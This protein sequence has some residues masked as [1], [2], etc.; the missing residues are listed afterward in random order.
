M[1]DTEITKLKSLQWPIAPFRKGRWTEYTSL[2]G[3]PINATGRI[4]FDAD[5]TEW[6]LTAMGLAHFDG[7]QFTNLTPEDGLPA[8]ASPLAIYLDHG[9]TLWMG[10]HDGL[11]RYNPGEGGK[12][13]KFNETGVPTDGVMEITGTPDGAVWWRT[14]KPQI[15][16]RYKSGHATLFTNLWRGTGDYPQHLAVAANHLWVAGQGVGLIRFDG[17]NQVR[18]GPQ[19]GLLSDDTGPVTV[20]PDGVVWL[21]VSTN[22]IARFDGTNFSYITRRDGL[23]KGFVSALYVAPGGELWLGF[24]SSPRPIAGS[25]G[26]VA[27]FDGRT[28][29]VF[30]NQENAADHRNASVFDTCDDICTG[31]QGATW[32]GTFNGLFR[33][34]PATLVTYTSADGLRSGYPQGILATGDGSVWLNYTNGLTRLSGGRF[35]DYA[36]KNL[37]RGMAVLYRAFTDTNLPPNG[38][39]NSLAMGP[40]G[41]LWAAGLQGNAGIERFDGAEFQPPITNFAGLPTNT[42]SCLARAP[43]GAVWVGTTAGGVA[44]FDGRP[45]VVTLTETNGLLTNAVNTIHCD[46]RGTVWIGV[47]GGIVRYDGNNWTEFTQTNGAPGHYIYAIEDGK[48]GTVW[49]GA[50]DGGL[51]RFDGKTLRQ[52]PRGNRNLVPSLVTGIL[53]ATDGSLW[54]VTYRGV[55]HYDGIAW[56]S[57]DEGDGLLPGY[58]NGIAQDRTGAIWVC[59]DSG[60]TRYQP[61]SSAASAPNLVVQTDMAYT[62]LTALPD[63]TAG[64]L[65]TFKCEAADYQ[66]VPGKR[67]YRYAVVPG[68]A[69]TPPAKMD[70][71]WRAPTR[72]AQFEW[73]ASK[74]GDY[75]VFVQEID[76]DLNYSPAAVAHLTI[77]P[78][79]YLNAFIMV[80]AGGGLLGLLGWAFVARLL[81]VRRKREADELRERM[82]EQEREASRKLRDSEA[83]YASL[84]DN[85]DQWLVR[86]DLEGRYTFVNEP[87]AR[88]YGKT[89]REMIGM[90]NFDF[91]DREIAEKLHAKDRRV[92]ETG[93]PDRSDATVRDPRDPSKLHWFE[94]FTTP[95]CDSTGKII[96]LQILIWETTQQ[97]LAEQELKEAKE[98]ADDANQAKSQFLASMSHELRTPLNAIIG[99]SEMLQ[100][101]AQ[102]TGQEGFVPDLERIHAAARHQLGLINDILDLSKIEAGKMT[103]FLEDF[104]VAKLVS[105]VASTAQPLV[106]KNANRLEVKCPDD[107]GSMRADL[108]KVRQILFNLLSNASKFT[109][110]GTIKL[111]VK[112]QKS[113]VRSSHPRTALPTSDLRPLTSVLFQVSDTGIGMTPEQLSRLFQAFTQADASTTRKYG[114]TGLGLALSR[115]F[116][117]MMGGEVAVQSEYGKGTVFTVTLPAEVKEPAVAP[118]PAATTPTPPS[119]FP[120]PHSTLVLVID[121]DPTVQDL[122]RRTLAK[123]G[124]GVQIA[125]SGQQ[126]LA[127]ARELKPDA[128]TLDVMMPGMDGWAVLTALKADPELAGIP[129]IMVSILDE[130]KMGFA[131]GVADYLTKP[132]DWNR[133]LQLLNKYR[134]DSQPVLVVDDDPAVRELLQRQLEKA[135]WKVMTAENGRAGLDRL[136]AQT[137]AIIVLDLLMPELDGFGFMQALRRHSEWRNVPIIVITS[138]NL[139]D[140]DRQRLNGDVNDIL[141]KGAYSTEELLREIR[142]LVAARRVRA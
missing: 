95:L 126:G 141:Q 136:R 140:E 75:T 125:S 131:L 63:I 11:W 39:M 81:V 73:P 135:G 13:R 117:Q 2:D 29:T 1:S 74:R 31:P 8:F 99:Y 104:D 50:A 82:F 93:Q 89:V 52:V 6:I 25:G 54:F 72:E 40:D 36:G 142:R 119:A 83:L 53:R 64:R 56:S 37:P 22:E 80:P 71:L 85:L 42:I 65:V 24:S 38:S 108:T 133:L 47:D 86:Q 134:R 91:L 70:A 19:Q 62:N 3:L 94:G 122:M 98:V 48:D 123:E 58:L 78:P 20:A 113:E 79:W 7:R 76:R 27:R 43:D 16:V 57:L 61:T 32:F 10:T 5:G 12:P 26:F 92:I 139:T 45:A 110:K 67:L 34:G 101:E 23:P 124:F 130:K 59:G 18:F 107:I 77:V 105:E 14:E 60:L 103:L 127:L 132:I 41:C 68:R 33:Y 90:T 4:L 35:T 102:E 128:I 51:S 55:T 115:K 30:G 138:K 87:F 129:V 66:T 15:L 97:K 46:T 106:A 28:F 112:G 17:T 114:G 100:E 137:P 96:G 21:A 120:T 111:E 44:R 121:D 116:A 88:F 109:E 9:G 69:G 49:L 84:V 118:A